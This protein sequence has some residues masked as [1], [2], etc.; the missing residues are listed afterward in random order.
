MKSSSDKEEMSGAEAIR[1]ELRFII[2][3]AIHGS[4]TE[5]GQDQ[6]GDRE[7]KMS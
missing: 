6:L 4:C 7:H 2:L 1:P 3:G 5:G